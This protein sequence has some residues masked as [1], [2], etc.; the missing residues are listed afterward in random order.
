MPRSWPRI[1][2]GRGGVACHLRKFCHPVRDSAAPVTRVMR[3][4]SSARDLLSDRRARPISGAMYSRSRTSLRAICRILYKSICRLLEA[5]AVAF[6]PGLG[7]RH[8][9]ARR[10]VICHHMAFR[11]LRRA[12]LQRARLARGADHKLRLGRLVGGRRRR[13]T[14]DWRGGNPSLLAAR[15]CS[16]S[17]ALGFEAI[18]GPDFGARDIGRLRQPFGRFV[19]GCHRGDGVQDMIRKL[20]IY[21]RDELAERDKRIASFSRRIRA[22]F[23]TN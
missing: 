20:L 2:A 22:L 15:H 14:A 19:E 17:R 13:N 9:G 5:A 21:N 3:Q 10:G 7:R 12:G 16:R 23:R 8:H 11:Q 6:Q 1:S 4:A 18:T